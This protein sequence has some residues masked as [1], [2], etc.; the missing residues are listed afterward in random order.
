VA[1]LIF[2]GVQ[3]VDYTGPYEVFGQA[4]YEVFTVAAS[5]DP[6]VTNMGMTVTPSYT[7]ANAPKPDIM[8]LPGGAV[9]DDIPKSNPAIRWIL[10]N[11][12]RTDFTLSVCNGAFWLA[13]A[14]LLE[15]REATTYYGLIEL[16]RAKFPNVKVVNDKR[17]CDNGQIITTAGLSSG[18]DGALHV[19]EKL[20]GVAKARGVALNMEY[21]W[22][23]ES[24]YAR[25][26]FADRFLR[27][28]EKARGR[29]KLPDGATA[30]LMD[31]SGTRDRWNEVWQIE[32]ANVNPSVLIEAAG[33]LA[34]K[35][36]KSVEATSSDQR[37][38]NFT[39]EKGVVW[40][41][42]IQVNA[43]SKVPNRYLV[44]LALH[45]GA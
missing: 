8:V 25:G 18:I 6:L 38:W 37:A 12:P 33:K 10:E 16:L 1:I 23:P 30:K 28:A 29:M 3:I 24:G 17:Y 41:A 43:D 22:Q 19:V 13:N 5:A 44:T 27:T 20:D 42:N 21:N 9:E 34:P 26:A 40:V 32:G 11:S 7:F 36:W 35:S 4:G 15:G 31:V 39:D 14:G 45:K 2:P